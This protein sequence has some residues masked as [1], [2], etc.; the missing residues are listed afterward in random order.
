MC[1]LSHKSPIQVP[2]SSLAYPVRFALDRFAILQDTLI[3]IATKNSK[4]NLKI[5][6][7]MTAQ[8]QAANVNRLANIPGA[9]DCARG[10]EHARRPQKAPWQKAAARY[11]AQAA[12]YY[13]CL[14]AEGPALRLR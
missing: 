14:Q 12:S 9:T 1:K 3:C 4:K 7:R 8:E 13:A 5:F 6:T 10:D 2:V 11:S